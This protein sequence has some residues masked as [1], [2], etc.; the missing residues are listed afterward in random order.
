MSTANILS[1]QVVFRDWIRH[2]AQKLAERI[3]NRLSVIRRT[4]S[5][6]LVH[7]SP[8]AEVSIQNQSMC[9]VGQ[10]YDDAAI[11]LVKLY[12][13]GGTAGS[14]TNARRSPHTRESLVTV[15]YKRQ[16]I[17]WL[18]GVSG[19]FVFREDQFARKWHIRQERLFAVESLKAKYTTVFFT[20]EGLACT[21]RMD[22]TDGEGES[23]EDLDDQLRWAQGEDKLDILAAALEAKDVD[24]YFAM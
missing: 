9:K 3:A 19:C 8:S 22:K 5:L 20:A 18:R 24:L 10:G 13:S 4:T 2:T 12:G 21:L 23:N 16:C 14:R 1:T 11:Q 7:Y 6:S 17:S 15:W